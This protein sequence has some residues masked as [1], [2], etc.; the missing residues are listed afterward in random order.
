MEALPLVLKCIW[1]RSF[2]IRKC[3]LHI[4]GLIKP[5]FGFSQWLRW[6]RVCLQCRRPQFDPW[7]R[8]IPWRRKLQPTPVFLPGEWATVHGIAKSPT[9]I[10]RL[11]TAQCVRVRLFR[12][13]ET[14]FLGQGQ[15]VL[16]LADKTVPFR[17][18]R[19]QLHPNLPVCS[20]SS[21]QDL[22]LSQSM[23]QL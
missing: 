9:R 8:K 2:S 22:V 12:K 18:V 15:K 17:N 10:R 14:S 13:R 11:S 16:L 5:L 20:H 7:V 23:T 1:I 3:I 4:Q 21:S 19:S 6:L